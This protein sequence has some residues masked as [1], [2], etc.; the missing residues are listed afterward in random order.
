VRVEI[1]TECFATEYCILHNNKAVV[2]S[3]QADPLTEGNVHGTSTFNVTVRPGDRELLIEIVGAW[4][5]A[6]IQ[7]DPERAYAIALREDVNL[8]FQ[9]VGSIREGDVSKALARLEKDE[10]FIVV[11]VEQK[12]D[13]QMRRYF[14]LTPGGKAVLARL[15]FV[16]F[17][18]K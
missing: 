11:A 6:L 14:K 2:E 7:N 15:P 17:R 13:G 9:D 8:Y 5:L 3:V 1:H 4:L 10:R 18:T 16:R 12:V